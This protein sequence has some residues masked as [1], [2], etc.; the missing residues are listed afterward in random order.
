MKL[1]FCLQ[2]AVSDLNFIQKIP[3]RK[4]FKLWIKTA[5]E[6]VSLKHLKA[7]NI[8]LT[9]RLVDEKESAALN[10]QY[11]AKTGPTNILS[12]AAEN[13]M[14][15]DSYY[16]GDLLICVP[17]VIQEAAEQNKTCIAHWAHLTVHGVLHLLGY[18]HEK[19]KD[20]MV[21]ERFE[22]TILKNLGYP[23]PYADVV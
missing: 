7:N 3:K 5:L 15:I 13:L 23:D 21:M 19:A 11:R 18:D 2:T 22:T 1:Q 9:I 20:A 14:E 4:E 8:E 12:F 17:L 6:A 16:L 10:E